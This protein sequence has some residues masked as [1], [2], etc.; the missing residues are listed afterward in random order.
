MP[1]TSISAA[2]ITLSSL[3]NEISLLKIQNNNNIHSAISAV[4]SARASLELQYANYDSLVA[5][6]RDVDI[7]YYEAALSQAI[8]ARNKAII[9]RQLMV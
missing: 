5:K 1:K 4:D 7:S 6:P 9:L 8:A 3:E 2:Q